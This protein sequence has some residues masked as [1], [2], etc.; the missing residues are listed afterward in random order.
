M[1]IVY[2]G[3]KPSG[4]IMQHGSEYVTS[5]AV[6]MYLCGIYV[7]LFENCLTSGMLDAYRPLFPNYQAL[8][9]LGL[10]SACYQNE[11]VMENYLRMGKYSPESMWS[12]LMGTDSQDLYMDYEGH[13]DANEFY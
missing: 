5:T 3:M 11:R 12:R 4:G 9:K 1:P 2:G 10:S 6:A 8:A 7:R 13:D